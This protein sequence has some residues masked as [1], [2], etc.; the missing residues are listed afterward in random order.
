MSGY[1][2]RVTLD[3]GWEKGRDLIDSRSYD[4]VL[5]R[6]AVMRQNQVKA[7]FMMPVQNV[8]MYGPLA[9]NRVTQESFIM[10]RGH[11]L[12]KDP[13]SEVTYLPMSLFNKPAEVKSECD[14]I[15]LLPTF[16]RLKPSCN[17]LKET[18]VTQYSYMPGHFQDG[19][20]GYSNV[21]YSNLQSRTNPRLKI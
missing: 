17:G 14:R 21:V 12:S 8:D 10:G 9:G 20:L 15:D 16:T 2:D 6:N 3:S 19:Y 18:E 7:P 11:T 4:Y 13:T 1:Y 5:N